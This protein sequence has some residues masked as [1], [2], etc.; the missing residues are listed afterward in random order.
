MEILWNKNLYQNVNPSVISVK[1]ICVMLLTFRSPPFKKKFK[2]GLSVTV[3]LGISYHSSSMIKFKFIE[4]RTRPVL[5]HCDVSMD[6]KYFWCLIAYNMWCS[7]FE[8]AFDTLPTKIDSIQFEPNIRRMARYQIK[9]FK[10][11]EWRL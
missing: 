10:F 8:T 9:Q 5:I 2:F 4:Q 1:Y 11:E 3:Y 7:V 6:F